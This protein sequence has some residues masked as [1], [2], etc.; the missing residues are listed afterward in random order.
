MTT[1]R[2]VAHNAMVMIGYHEEL[3]VD[4]PTAKVDLGELSPLGNV[5]MSGIAEP[6]VHITARPATRC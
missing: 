4:V 6:A 5:V 2:S 3:L 1:P